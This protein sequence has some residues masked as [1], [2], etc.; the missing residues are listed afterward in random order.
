MTLELHDGT[1]TTGSQI[2]FGGLYDID[3][4]QNWFLSAEAA[5]SLR[6]SE[7]YISAGVGYR[8]GTGNEPRIQRRRSREPEDSYEEQNRQGRNRPGGSSTINPDGSV[9][10]IESGEESE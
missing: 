8:L 4:H 1:Y 10:T 5:I 2:A 6:R 9:R 7:S 3:S